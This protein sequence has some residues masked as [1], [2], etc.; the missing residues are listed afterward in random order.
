MTS[1]SALTTA[2]QSLALLKNVPKAKAAPK[3][4]ILP[5]TSGDKNLDALLMGGTNVWHHAT[6]SV[7]TKT[8]N[9]VKAG[10]TELQNVVGR[11]IK[12]AFMD[13]SFLT[14]L[15]GSDATGAA[16]MTNTHLKHFIL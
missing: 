9:V 16:A 14:R 15:S 1:L 3:T 11:T 12:F 2:S 8:A 10:V 5:T 4:D 6:G 7:A 13:S